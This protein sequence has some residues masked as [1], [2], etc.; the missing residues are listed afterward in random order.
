MADAKRPDLRFHG[1]G[2]DG[3]V[4]VELKL[5]SNWTGPQLFERLENQLCGDYLRDVKSSR[6]IFLL[7][8]NGDKSSWEHPA[9][10]RLASF[11]AL[12]AGLQAH[13]EILSTKLANVEDIRIIGI[14]LTLRTA[15]PMG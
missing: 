8:H 7:V 4:P 15:K 12:V 14:D 9:G 11:D 13:W 10:G 3:P 1:M 5:A 2:F 6:G